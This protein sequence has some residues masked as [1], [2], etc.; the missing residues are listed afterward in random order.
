MTRESKT[1]VFIG[2]GNLATQLA[3]ALHSRGLYIR[4]IFSRTVQSAKLLA[5][6]VNADFTNDVQAIVRDADFYI[7]AYKDDALADIIHQ[8]R[9]DNGL[10]VHTSG[11]VSID[12]F[13]NERTH[14]GVFYPFQ[15]FSKQK[16]VGFS[17]LPVFIDANDENDKQQIRQ[18]AETVSQKVYELDDE[19][20]E[21]L[22]LAGV[23]ANNF[24][25]HCFVIAEQILKEKQLPFEVMMPLIKESVAKLDTLS[26]AQAQ[27]GPAV[28][29][30][31]TIINKHLTML[32][33]YPDWQKI[34]QQISE[35]IQKTN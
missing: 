27:T 28:R 32:E 14:Y 35:N 22:H 5:N 1:I 10:H 20:R 17:G 26:P 6:Q 12:V 15:T 4:Q 8:I 33:K 30:D 7:Y 9:I 18:L 16:K 3:P 31:K 23:F 24:S 11:S 29:H 13:K 2:A 21:T 34:Y 25:N 19:G